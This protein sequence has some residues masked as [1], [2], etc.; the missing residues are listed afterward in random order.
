MMKRIIATLNERRS[1]NAYANVISGRPTR[2][3][4]F[5]VGLGVSLTMFGLIISSILW[6]L[7]RHILVPLLIVCMFF[8]LHRMN[9]K[10]DSIESTLNNRTDTAIVFEWL[11]EKVETIENTN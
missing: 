1:M 5:I 6:Q 7:F 2:W 8:T 11:R 3:F 9:D 10:L 4:G